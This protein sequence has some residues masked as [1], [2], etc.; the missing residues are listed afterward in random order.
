MF[1]EFAAAI[2][3]ARAGCIP[4]RESVA[5]NETARALWRM[6]RPLDHL[7]FRL[8]NNITASDGRIQFCGEMAMRVANDVLKLLTRLEGDPSSEAEIV[9]A[10][11]NHTLDKAMML[12]YVEMHQREGT[13][14]ITARGVAA[15]RD[16]CVGALH[17]NATSNHRR[18]SRLSVSALAVA[19]AGVS[20][21]ALAE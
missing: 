7:A 21:F 10:G 1:A 20:V 15:L 2:E 13:V 5:V 16:A 14:S 11:F 19:A 3:H 9:Q 18:R 17:T 6:L 4:G 8:P 12:N